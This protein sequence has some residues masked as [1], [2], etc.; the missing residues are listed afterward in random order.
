[1]SHGVGMIV[2]STSVSSFHLKRNKAGEKCKNRIEKKEEQ[3]LVKQEEKSTT[4][5]K[6]RERSCK[7]RINKTSLLVQKAVYS[8]CLEMPSGVQE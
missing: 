4:I 8:K 3:N 1:M 5:Q 7:E 6:L 2:R